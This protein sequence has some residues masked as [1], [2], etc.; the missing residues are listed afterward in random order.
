MEENGLRIVAF[1]CQYCAYAAAD[2]AGQLRLQYPPTIKVVH[3]PCTGKLDVLMVL[4]ALEEGADGVM[5]VGCMPGDCHF[6]EGN[7]NAARRME[8]ARM[9]I[10]EIGLEADRARMFNLSSA[11]AGR[12]AEAATEMNE[13]IAALGP[14]PLRKNL[15]ESVS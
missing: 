3:L 5:A 10:A 1:C 11:M 7:L 13:Q 14:S 2:L 8:H 15:E 9:L 6:L 4:Q 12:F